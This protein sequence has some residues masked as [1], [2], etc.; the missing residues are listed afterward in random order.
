MARAAR[1]TTTNTT[2]TTTSARPPAFSGEPELVVIARPEVGLRASGPEIAAAGADPAPLTKLLRGYK[3]TLQPLFGPS[4]ERLYNEVAS[5]AAFADV[6]DLAAYYRVEA[7]AAEMSDIAAE[8]RDDPLVLAAYVKP[9]AEPAEINDMAPTADAA[10]AV[11]P[12]FTNRQIYLNAAPAGVD[13]RFA[14]TLAGGRGANVRII[15][16]EGAWRFTHEDLTQNQ[17]G[18]VAGTQSPDLVW[19][20]HG[21]AV[22]GEFGGDSNGF[23]VTGICPDAIVSAISIFGGLGSAAAIKNAANRL[24]AGDVILIELHR[25]GP[26]NNFQGRADQNG[27]IA[28]EWWPDDFD[29]IRFAV[30]KGIIVVEAAGNGAQNLDDAIYNN[31]APGFPA[32]W[33]NPFNRANRDSG[34]ILVGAGAPP[35]GTHGRDHGPDRSRLD[36]SNFGASLDV[37]GWGR[38]VTTCGYGDL[39]GGANEDLWYT[40]QF[41]GTSS[42]SPIVVGTLGAMQGVLRARGAT[43][44]TPA[45]ARQLLRTTGSPQQDAPGRPRTQ[46]IGNRPDLRALVAAVTA[47]KHLE[48]IIKEGDKFKDFKDV[49]EREKIIKEFKERE[50]IKDLKEFKEGKEFEKGFEIPDA[51]DAPKPKPLK[52]FKESIKELKEPKEVKDLKDDKERPKELKDGKDGQKDGKEPKEFKETK[53]FKEVK[54]FAKENAKELKEGSKELKEKDRKDVFEKTSKEFVERPLDLDLDQRLGQ[55]EQTLGQLMHFIGPE[56]RPDLSTS[57]LSHEDPTQG[58]VQALSASL[59]K[60]ATDAKTAKDSKDVD[61]VADR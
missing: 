47:P 2:R 31:P 49:K 14:W 33:T 27:Y 16:I 50:K 15:D 6:P 12:D 36:F 56:L 28:I 52:E 51:G 37:Q 30:A 7:P 43:V 23:G 10:P 53:E 26:R 60:Q 9:P 61:K 58:D 25:P 20:N 17:G 21:T 13:A 35:P 24:Q 34:A 5:M 4:E 41:S 18:V 22:V 40:D 11:T 44:L 54:E 32:G 19:R 29:A 45:R 8:L 42:A 55:I 48:K 57:A 46:R 38:E 59:Q 3:A 39:Q 1:K